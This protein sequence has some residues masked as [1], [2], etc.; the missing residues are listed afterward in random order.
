MHHASHVLSL[1]LLACIAAIFPGCDSGGQVEVQPLP[2]A[3]AMRY[4]SGMT[5]P[6][7]LVVRDTATWTELWPQIVGSNRP[8]PPVPAV[9]FSDDLVIVAAMG[10]KPTGGYS[11]DVDE[12]RVASEDA[13]ISVQSRSPATGCL[14]TPLVTA[15]LSIV[16][17]PRF[18]GR[19]TFVEHASQRT[20]D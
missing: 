19:P 2:E 5:T 14:V 7:R 20:C 16:V 1:L 18:A 3:E 12:V 8:I 6:Q 9:D 11:I 10:T 17:V 4:H 15:P 13:A